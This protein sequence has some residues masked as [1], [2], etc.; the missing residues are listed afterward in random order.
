MSSQSDQGEHSEES[1]AA[2]AQARHPWVPFDEPRREALLDEIR[3][4]V[5]SH[6][7]AC[8]ILSINRSTLDRWIERGKQLDKDDDD[9][10]PYRAFVVALRAGE[11]SRDAMPEKVVHKAAMEDYRAAL[12]MLQLAERRQQRRD[13]ARLRKAIAER[14]EAEAKVS[15]LNAEI[16]ERQLRKNN[17][18]LYVAPE[19]AALMNDEERR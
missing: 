14:A 10:A 12:P 19:M 7:E 1:E 9:G 18:R 16:L 15:Q 11:A 13:G 3:S 8:R 6:R 4:G 17:G 5:R 2:P